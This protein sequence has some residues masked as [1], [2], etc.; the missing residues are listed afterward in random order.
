MEV[1]GIKQ[2]L[3]N[4]SIKN[5]SFFFNFIQTALEKV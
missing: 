1:F 5:D 4:I 3:F 2:F